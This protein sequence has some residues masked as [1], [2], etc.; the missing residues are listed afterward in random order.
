MAVFTLHCWQGIDPGSPT[1]NVAIYQGNS[2]ATSTGMASCDAWPLASGLGCGIRPAAAWRHGQ[3]TCCGRSETGCGS[4]NGWQTSKRFWS[5]CSCGIAKSFE[6]E[7]WSKTCGGEAPRS[8]GPFAHWSLS[9][10]VCQWHFSNQCKK[11]TPQCLHYCGFY[12]HQWRSLHQPAAWCLS[13][14]AN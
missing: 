3:A 2:T 12:E 7:I 8:V 4:A 6:N 14:P 13:D 11:Q 1:R 10:P 9:H 5:P